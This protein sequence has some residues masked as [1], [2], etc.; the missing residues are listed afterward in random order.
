MKIASRKTEINENREGES[1]MKIT[2]ERIE[3]TAAPCQ[4]EKDIREFQ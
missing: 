1:E 4:I 3:I 2:K